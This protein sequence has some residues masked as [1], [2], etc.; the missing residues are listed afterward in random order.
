MCAYLV[1]PLSLASAQETI[2]ERLRFDSTQLYLSIEEKWINNQINGDTYH[3]WH[4]ALNND[5]IFLRP[6]LIGF[7]VINC[8]RRKH[9]WITWMHLEIFISFIINAVHYKSTSCWNPCSIAISSTINLFIE[10]LHS[11][12]CSTQP[13]GFQR[14]TFAG[15]DRNK[16]RDK[17]PVRWRW[18]VYN[19]TPVKRFEIS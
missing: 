13:C 1:Y 12:L 3:R 10:P 9:Y 17:R 4:A 5:I 11:F 8:A 7:P 19:W 15:I 16:K 2:L 6:K 18:S 14:K